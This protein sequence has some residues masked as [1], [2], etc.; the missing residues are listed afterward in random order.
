MS[1]NGYG[2]GGTKESNLTTQTSMETSDFVRI[3]TSGS[4][5]ITLKS[6]L[7]SSVAELKTLGFITDIVNVRLRTIKNISSNYGLLITDDIVI[8]NAT[9]VNIGI[10][11]MLA[12][13]AY[14]IPTTSGYVFTI[15]RS[16]TSTNIVT[17]NTSGGDLIDGE[18]T[19][20]LIGVNRPYV[21]IVSD[22]SNW[23]TI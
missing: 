2:H 1:D 19:V 16:D 6:L 21:Q 14:D 17:L 15:K 7:A 22:G 8:A 13:I 23:W 5:K 3:V 20:Q 12:S 10:N 18:P 11:L 4:R 9:S